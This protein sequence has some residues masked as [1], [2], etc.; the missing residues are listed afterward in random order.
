MTD[1]KFRP[2][3]SAPSVR[4]TVG[5]TIRIDGQDIGD[6]VKPSAWHGAGPTVTSGGAGA[7]DKD[8]RPM[9]QQDVVKDMIAKLDLPAS[10]K[11]RLRQRHDLEE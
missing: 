2:K 3:P 8:E 1:K 10:L 11:T 6:I 7:A 4:Q 9:S 5:A